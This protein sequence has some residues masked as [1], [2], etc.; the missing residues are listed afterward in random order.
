MKLVEIFDSLGMSSIRDFVSRRQEENLYLDF[1]TIVDA[2]LNS[3]DDKRNLA[4][5]LSG[6]ANSSGGLI[7][8]GIEARKDTDGVDCA[9]ALKPIDRVGLFVSRLNA[10]TGGAV[11]PL[12]DGVR[13]RAVEAGSGTGFAVSL[14]PES[15]TG[16]HMAKLGEDRYYKRS[17]DSFYKMEHYDVADMFGRRRRPTLRVTYRIVG[18]GPH[19]AVVLGLRNVGRATARA[20]FLA[21]DCESTLQRSP[22][23]LDGNGNEGLAYLR[24]AYAGMKWAYGGGMDFAVHPGMS[25]DVACL[26]LGIPARPAPTE[27]LVVKYAVAC[28]DQQIEQGEILIPIAELRSQDG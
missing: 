6:F 11:D 2:S 9:T 26:N 19:A 18:R 23:G 20:P 8:W 22:Y 12:V 1:K 21:L 24:F 28:E 16:P 13:H 14:I 27:D 10:L 4:R 7:V 15:D 5:A 3:S 17:G 25:Y